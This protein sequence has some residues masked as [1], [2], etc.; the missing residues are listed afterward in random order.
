[1]RTTEGKVEILTL[2]GGAETDALD[3]KILDESRGDADDHVLDEAAGGAVE[4]TDLA[5]LGGAGDDD[6]AVFRL[7]GDAFRKG[8]VE[9]ALGAFDD[10][11]AAVELDGDFFGK[12]DWFESDS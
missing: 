10:D 3:F 7:E 2:D 4:G 12:R 5:Q 9:F 1:M 11:R 8:E 6:G